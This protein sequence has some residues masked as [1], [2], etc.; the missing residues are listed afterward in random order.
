MTLQNRDL[1][2]KP[3]WSEQMVGYKI[4]KKNKE[5]QKLEE[6]RMNCKTYT[7]TKDHMN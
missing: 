5:G 3:E 1:Q 6:L 4:Q 7:M 2:I